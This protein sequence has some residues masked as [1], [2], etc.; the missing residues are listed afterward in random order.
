M[1]MHKALATVAV[2]MMSVLMAGTLSANFTI[3]DLS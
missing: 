1:N 3:F 2:M